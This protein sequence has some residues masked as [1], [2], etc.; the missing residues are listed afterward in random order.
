MK[1]LRALIPIKLR[2]KLR[3]YAKTVVGVA[4]SVAMVVNIAAPQYGETTTLVVAAIIGVIG[5]LG[6]YRV[7]NVRE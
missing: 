6:I 7:P 1:A 4:T 2:R 3:P 5:S